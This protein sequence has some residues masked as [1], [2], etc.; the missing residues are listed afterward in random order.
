MQKEN[1][2][3]RLGMKLTGKLLLT[4]A[5]TLLL[6]AC[7]NTNGT[8][9]T[10]GKVKIMTTFYPMYDFTKNIVGDEGDVS[11]L[12]NG[13]VE[14]HD[15]EPSAKDIA[16]ISES[17]A[18]VYDNENMETW[19]PTVVDSLT[20]S[21]V[22]PIK[23]T[24]DLVLLPGGE[25]EEHDHSEQGHHHEYDPHLWLSPYRAKMLVEKITAQL[26][27]AFPEKASAFQTNAQ[28]YLEKLSQL[29]EEYT[30]AFKDAKQKNFVTQHTAFHYLALDYGLNQVGITGISPE[31]EPTPSRLAE[32]TKYIK[33]NGIQYIYFEENA[34]EKI[35]QT[36]ATETGVELAVLNPLESLTEEAQKQGE[37]YISVMKENLTALRKTTDVAGTDIQ[38]EVATDTKTVANGYFED[39]DVKDRTLSDYA[40][41]WQSVYPY[42]LDGT[43]DQVFDYK[44]KLSPSMTTAEYKDYYTAGYKTD[45]KQINITDST[46]EFVKDDGTTASAQYRYVGYKILQYQKGNRGVRYLFESTTTDSSAPK[47][48]QFS[49]HNIAPVK[50]AHFHIFAGDESQEALLEEMDNWPTYYPTTL[51]GF[52]I[53]QEMIAH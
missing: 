18:L 5:A 25:E 42:L 22:K 39:K 27:E 24:Q 2:G 29:D 28:A 21:K 23:A 48:V 11:L 7:S 50:T 15:Y 3:K 26:S 17:D 52:E 51:T 16:K 6:G 20:E 40:G 13:G 44:S 8:A 19:V 1:N 49:D 4:A 33:D 45:V 37:D 36:L 10:T 34:S 31:T 47:Y 12:I 53:A 32:L 46:M 43:L 14:P 30:A 41:K 35:A 9:T 38:P